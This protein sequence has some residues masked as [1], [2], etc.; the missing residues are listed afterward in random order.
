M[1]LLAVGAAIGI[2]TALRFRD[3]AYLFVFLWAYTGILQNHLSPAGFGGAY[4][5]V[6]VMASLSLAAFA[7]VILALLF[8]LKITK[9]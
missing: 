7:A 1:I 6:I 9:A 2:V 3:A 5:G 4:P 8:R